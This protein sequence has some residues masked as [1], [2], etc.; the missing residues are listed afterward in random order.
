MTPAITI[1]PPEL[2]SQIA[3]G[4]V[5]ER[6]A[7]V[8]KELVENALDAGASAIEIEV[9]L[10]R[11]RIRVKDDGCGIAPG[12][13][14]LALARHGTSKIKNVDGIFGITSYGFRGE[15]LPSIASVSRLTLTSCQKGGGAG[16]RIVVEGGATVS[17]EDA[18]PLT[19]TE[20]L[21]ENLFF[22]TPARRKFARSEATEMGQ[23]T[24]RVAQAALSAPGVRFNFIKDGKRVMEL[25]PAGELLERVRQ[26]FGAEYA[27]NL[28]PISHADFNIAV[29]GLA[30]KPHF[31]RATA[32]DQYF[33]I[34]GRPVK[35]ALV[36]SAVLRAFDDLVPK[37]RK[38]V[39]FLS[40]RL[41]HALVDV[42]VHPAKAEV[43]LADPSKVSEMIV[44]A[45][46][47]AFHRS[48]VPAAPVPVA[49][50][51]TS[52]FSPPAAGNDTR[53]EFARAFE[54]WRPPA[55]APA[56]EPQMPLKTA[57]GNISPDAA[58]VGQLFGTFILFEEG[59]R[60]IIMDQHAV[61]ERV[62]HE[63]FMRRYL[64][65]EVERQGLLV[66][67]TLN[68]GPVNAGVI[69]GHLPD[70]ARLGWR[71]EEFG[72]DAFV[73]REVPAILKD[74]DVLAAAMDIAQTLG[75]DR[76]ADY[77]DV[78]TD[79]VSRIACRAAVKAGDALN[80]GEMKGLAEELARADL[81]YTCPH[82]RPVAY[83]ITRDE[84]NR[85]FG[86]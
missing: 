53:A 64:A 1:L 40:L 35:D 49:R 73:I 3:A 9:S 22:N 71:L 44:T 54:L 28:V 13:V 21:V 58:A 41:P 85:Y 69:K 45:I 57:H 43:R 31:H 29:G 24:A 36:R 14:E 56:P 37:G 78:L 84:L 72:A 74:K 38:P 17:V 76:D 47:K 79:C 83:T 51:D 5:V 2:A 46:R 81:P 52:G 8:V 27:D 34:N 70:F 42:N 4:E 50:Q 65:G 80:P 11:R 16:R 66:P 20:V 23:I 26:V 75:K 60:L 25:A 86:R 61:H 39:V 67:L 48:A 33:F 12:E 18:P 82:G 19:G 59:E 15:A 7:S 32:I 30:G 68:A 63:R 77:K 10:K 62:L 6:P 55:A